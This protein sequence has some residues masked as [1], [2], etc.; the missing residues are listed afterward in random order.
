MISIIQSKVYFI[1]QTVKEFLLRKASTKRPAG[2]VWQHSLNLEVSHHLLAKISL[3]TIS[4]SEV[5]LYQASLYN[6][7]LPEEAREME[8]NAY[9]RSYMLLSYSAVYWADYFRDQK[10]NKGIESVECFLKNSNCRSV[11]GRWGR[12]YVNILYAASLGGHDKVVQILL[13]KGAEVNAQGGLYSNALQAA[14]SRGHNKVV[15]MLLEKGAEVNAQ[16][17]FYSNALYAALE[18]GYNK[19]L[20]IL[21]EKG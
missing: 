2:R 16:G 8:P 13:E 6:A 1:H 5:E 9:C 15:Q 12:N 4:F 14:S 7:V 20:N 10:S 11:I 21:L 19:E 17:G 3:R 18:R